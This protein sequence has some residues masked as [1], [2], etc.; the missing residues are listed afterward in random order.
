M[1]ENKVATQISRFL[2]DFFPKT[3]QK[4]LNPSWKLFFLLNLWNLKINIV[5]L[6]LNYLQ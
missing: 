3:T 5:Y 4:S 1:Y 6:I 2:I